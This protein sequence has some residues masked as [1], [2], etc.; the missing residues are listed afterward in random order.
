V[1][2][3]CAE[4]LRTKQVSDNTFRAV[5]DRVG[6]RGVVELMGVMGYYQIVSMLLNIDR[7]PMPDGVAPELQP[8]ERSIH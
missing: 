7:Y 2:E 8:S 4:L 6:E 5:K 3:F 1:Y